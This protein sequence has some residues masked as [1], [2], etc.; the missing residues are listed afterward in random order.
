MLQ[1]RLEHEK[2]ICLAVATNWAGGTTE[3]SEGWCR[4]R[5]QTECEEKDAKL[6]ELFHG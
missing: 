3:T 4:G 6:E 2:T 1:Q 5:R